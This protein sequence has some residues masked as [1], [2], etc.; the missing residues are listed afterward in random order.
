MTRRKQNSL[1]QRDARRWKQC[2]QRIKGEKRDRKEAESWGH[3]EA[4][5]A[6]M[7]AADGGKRHRGFSSGSPEKQGETAQR[8][9]VES[10]PL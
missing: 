9:A 6:R 7:R 2:Q 3:R 10:H 1:E 8:L 5:E 4:A